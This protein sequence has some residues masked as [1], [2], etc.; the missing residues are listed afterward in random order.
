MNPVNL[1]EQA[2]AL[3]HWRSA[4]R[5]WRASRAGPLPVLSVVVRAEYAAYGVKSF[6]CPS[7]TTSIAPFVTW[8]A[9]SSSIA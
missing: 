3:P 5:S 6:Q 1:L 4:R 8:M 2:K 7:E 9:L